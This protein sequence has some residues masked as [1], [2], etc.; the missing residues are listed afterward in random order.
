MPKKTQEMKIME[1]LKRYGRITTIEARSLYG[2]TRPSNVIHNL[3]CN[4]FNIETV[5]IE[6]INRY[7]NPT[8]YATYVLR[9]ESKK[10]Q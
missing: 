3:R 5:R 6:A 1:H 4:G 2:I 8:T 9:K 7:G 10:F